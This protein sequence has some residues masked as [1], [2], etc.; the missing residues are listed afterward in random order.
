MAMKQTWK[1]GDVTIT[2]I[3]E[4]VV[5]LALGEFLPEA[6]PAAL[7]PHRGWLEPHFLAPD[8]TFE[9]SIHGL[10]VDAGELTILV[11]TCLG[12][13]PIPGFENIGD[14]AEDFLAGLAAA[15]H[16]RESIDVVLCTHLHFDHVGWNVMRE[17]DR[18]V[19]SFPNARYLF[20]RTEW[21]HWSSASGAEA[22]APTI[23]VA[24]RPIVEAGLADFVESD[25]KL[26]DTVR[27]VPTAGHTPGHVSV[28]IAS[29]G[30]RALITGDMT[31]HPVQWAEPDWKM[32][33]DS[34]SVAAAATRRRI[35]GSLA[36]EP[37]LVIGTH[38]APPCA[39]HLV[40]GERGVWFRA[41][42]S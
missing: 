25:H 31:H 6:T 11:D 9:L 22:F 28:E 23:G 33:A 24:V 7:A 30:E 12:P 5:K 35:A 34:D 41:Q 10:V 15:G 8:G 37:V 42:R 18:I 40:R 19:P 13:H 27:L 20:G 36:D 14:G 4:V 39:G 1:V 26:C 16:P 3:P 29:R 32:P 2:R 38:Y 17:G 21:E